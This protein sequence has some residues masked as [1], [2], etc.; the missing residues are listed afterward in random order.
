MKIT[1]QDKRDIDKTINI[2]ESL[3]DS[4]DGLK[5]EYTYCDA[6]DVAMLWLERIEKEK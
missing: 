4:L 6:I 2:L 1:K 3:K 5:D